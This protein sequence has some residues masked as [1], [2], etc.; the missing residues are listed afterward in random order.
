MLWTLCGL[1]K[2][3]KSMIDRKLNYAPGFWHE[4]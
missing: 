2:E 3:L 1:C 4:S